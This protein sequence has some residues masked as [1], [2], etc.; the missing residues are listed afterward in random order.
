MLG[1]DKEQV[2]VVECG[3]RRAV[4]AKRR[5][6]AA[7]QEQGMKVRFSG[8]DP[9]EETRAQSTDE[10]DA[11]VLFGEEAGRR[12]AREGRGDAGLVRR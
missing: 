1:L 5:K 10:Q 6:Q 8:Q 4:E 3:I 7:E 11:K 12:A 2:A 9:P